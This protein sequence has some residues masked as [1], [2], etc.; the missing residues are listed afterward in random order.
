[1]LRVGIIYYPVGVPRAY[2][3]LM[4]ASRIFIYTNSVG[5]KFCLLILRVFLGPN[6][7]S[8]QKLDTPLFYV[9]N[10]NVLFVRSWV[11]FGQQ[12]VNRCCKEYITLTG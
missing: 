6:D 7:T 9:V 10:S 1:M 11:F 4:H 3:A 2:N 5:V 8:R 12:M